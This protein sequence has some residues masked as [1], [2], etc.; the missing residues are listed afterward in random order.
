MEIIYRTFDGQE[1]TSEMDARKHESVLSDGIVMIG[2]DGNKAYRTEDAFI[3]WLKNEEANLAFFALAEN[4]GD[5]D[6][7]GLVKGEDYGLFY[8]DEYEGFYRWMDNEILT[9]LVRARSI[10]QEKGGSIN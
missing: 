4:Q 9:A 2:R 3:L 8:W 10:V 5:T 7:Q 1:F 6:I